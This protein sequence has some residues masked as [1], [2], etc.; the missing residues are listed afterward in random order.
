MTKEECLYEYIARRSDEILEENGFDRDLSKMEDEVIWSLPPEIRS[1]VEPLVD[2]IM[3][4]KFDDC[5][6]VYRGAFRDGM[7]YA[8]DLIRPETANMSMTEME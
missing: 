5:V 3:R 4:A 1:K 6:T 2:R 7:R 8:I